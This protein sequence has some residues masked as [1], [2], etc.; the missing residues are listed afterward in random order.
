MM[1]SC[2]GLTLPDFIAAKSRFNFAQRYVCAFTF[3][4]L[5]LPQN[6]QAGGNFEFVLDRNEI[7]IRNHSKLRFAVLV[8]NLRA[9]SK[10]V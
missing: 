10:H 4:R 1:I 8:E 2:S 3:T 6:P 9:K 7:G 5:G